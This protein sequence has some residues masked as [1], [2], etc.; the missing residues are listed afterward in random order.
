ME[1]YHL[2]VAD[3]EQANGIGAGHREIAEETVTGDRTEETTAE[4]IKKMAFMKEYAIWDSMARGTT[5]EVKLK[6]KLEGLFMGEFK[7]NKRTQR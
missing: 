6:H 4:A 2:L 3:L 1:S 7:N 5:A